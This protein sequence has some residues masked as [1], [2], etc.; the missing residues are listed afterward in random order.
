MISLQNNGLFNNKKPQN[1]FAK[2]RPFVIVL[3]L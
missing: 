2:P 3:Q 1:N